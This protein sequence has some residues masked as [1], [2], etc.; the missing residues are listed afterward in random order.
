[1]S[2]YQV[3]LVAAA[4]WLGASVAL[5][6]PIFIA[7]FGVFGVIALTRLRRP[8]MVMLAAFVL[9]SSLSFRSADLSAVP[10][11]ATV[12]GEITLASDPEPIARGVRFD[13][14]H[15]GRRYE[16]VAWGTIAGQVRSRLLGERIDVSGSIRPVDRESAWLRLRGIDGRLSIDEVR[17]WRVGAPHYRIANSIRRTIESGASGLPRDQRVL[18]VGLVYGDDRF[19]SDAVSDDFAAAGLTH[20][21]AVS[22]QNVVFVMVI[23][24]PVLR[25][26]D[27]RGRFLLILLTLFLF[28]TLTRFEPS[29]LRASTM[30][31]VA[32]FSVLL[33]RQGSSRRFLWLAIA[34]LILMQPRIVDS[35]AFQLSV[36]A[37]AGILFL[38][39]R[40]TAL[41]R[42]PRMLAEAIAVTTAAQLA[43]APIIIMTFD[44]LPVASLPANVLAGPAAGP[45]MM[46]GLVGGYVAGLAPGL[47]STLHV[48]SAL[49][50]GWIA[51]VARWSATLPLGS[52]GL[53]HVVM[54]A[55]SLTALATAPSGWIRR[56]ALVGLAIA[57]LHPGW[58][59]HTAVPESFVVV[60]STRVWRDRETTVVE[61]GSDRLADVLAAFR[62]RRVRTIDVLVLPKG[63]LADWDRLRSVKQRGRVES[64]WAPVDHT[65][66]GVAV[67]VDGD[68]VTVDGQIVT[69]KGQ[70]LVVVSNGD[71]LS[72][73]VS[74]SD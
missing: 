23:V 22:G 10:L 19:Q 4:C 56:L 30:A 31:A 18:L 57:V 41:T 1:M 62:Q 8:W 67:P 7:V 65:I 35:L 63:G 2:D 9:A 73:V 43:V 58:V 37:S 72:I 74:S 32:A 54:A 25:R 34:A 16:A 21:L 59:A 3:G 61:L 50:V 40:L 44:E 68:N 36:A 29:V 46:W 26:F 42:G 11:P 60:E 12:V 6:I 70:P 13:V 15:E 14:E 20:L 69:I 53:A 38:A 48:P 28:A 71:G 33:G 55:V 5:P 52:F 64:V 27:F 49:L 45:A 24:G 51:W 47:A 39:P 17:G 66:P